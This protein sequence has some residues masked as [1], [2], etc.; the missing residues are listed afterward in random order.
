MPRPAERECSRGGEARVRSGWTAVHLNATLEPPTRILAPRVAEDAR[1]ACITKNTP[2]RRCFGRTHRRPRTR[3]RDVRRTSGRWTSDAT[4]RGQPSDE[5]GLFCRTVVSESV[6]QHT[7][8]SIRSYRT[9]TM[10]RVVKRPVDNIQV[11]LASPGR[12]VAT[13]LTGNR[14]SSSFVV[15]TG[16]KRCTRSLG[17]SLLCSATFGRVERHI[18]IG[19]FR[20]RFPLATP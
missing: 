18:L 10:R 13:V 8:K 5:S 20:V 2:M 11:E 3:D 12:R 19:S 6:L 7:R 4:R 15:S 9:S 14:R 1:R 16:R 17:I